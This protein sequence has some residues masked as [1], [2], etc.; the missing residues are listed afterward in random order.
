[1][2]SSGTRFEDPARGQLFVISAPSGAGKTTLVRELMAR[3]VVDGHR[4]EFSVSHTTRAPRRGEV[5]GRDYHF[6]A[7]ERFREMIDQDLFL[8]WASVHGNLYGTS[9]GEIDPRLRDGSDV[10]LDIDVQGAEQ[11]FDREPAAL[12]IFVLPPS[13]EDLAVRLNGRALDDAETIARRLAVSRWEIERYSAYDYVI[14][15][16]EVAHSSA[17]LGAIILAERHRRQRMEARVASILE[18]YPHRD[19]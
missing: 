14:V 3:G 1:M 18:A 19:S 7:E 16:H 8:E 13:Y 2:D 5:D 6:V 15:N 9:R 17:V 12:G 10:L 4:L 11:V